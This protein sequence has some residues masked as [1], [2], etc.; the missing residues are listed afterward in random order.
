MTS[1]INHTLGTTVV[2]IP[3]TLS[4]ILNG[5]LFTPTLLTVINTV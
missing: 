2:K 1:I 3:N 4:E 5:L